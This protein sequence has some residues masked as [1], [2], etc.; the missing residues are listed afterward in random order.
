VQCADRR[1]S[2]DLPK[3]AAKVHKIPI[4]LT[5][6]ET[7]GK[8][9]QKILIKTDIGEG[10]VPAVTAQAEIKAPAPAETAGK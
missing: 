6:D 9:V 1:F 5:A 3:G 10:V 8:I 7:L 2:F 4:T